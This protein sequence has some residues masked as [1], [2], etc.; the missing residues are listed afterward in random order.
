[1]YRRSPLKSTPYNIVMG[2]VSP[3]LD[4]VGL[5]FSGREQDFEQVVLAGAPVA[6]VVADGECVTFCFDGLPSSS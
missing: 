1:M 5:G 3:A 6:P 4:G 2:R